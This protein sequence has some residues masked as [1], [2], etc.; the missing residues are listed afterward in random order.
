MESTASSEAQVL[1]P[2]FQKAKDCGN[3][4]YLYTLVRIDGMQCYEGYQDEFISLR[5]QL[6][7]LDPSDPLTH[8]RTLSCRHE[9]LDLIQNLLNCASGKYYDATPFRTLITGQYPNAVWP[10]PRQKA[11]YLSANARSS[12]FPELADQIEAAYPAPV[13]ESVEP[14][15]DAL[16]AALGTLADLLGDLVSRYFTKLVEFRKAPRY[17]K[18]PG[19]LDLL[20]LIVDEHLGLTGLRV[21]FS[22]NCSAEFIR[23]PHGVFPANLEFGP[24]ITFLRM[25]LEPSSNEYRVMGKRI[26][27]IGLPGRYNK[28]G[29]WKPLIYP[30][31]AQHLVDECLRLSKDPDVQ[32]ALLYTRLTGH[33][34]IEFAMK[35]DMELPGEYTKTAEGG[36]HIW[37]CPLEE[38]I[39]GNVRTYDCW[40]TLDSCSA[41]EIEGRLASVGWFM[42]VLFFPYGATYSWRNK[43][44]MTFGGKGVL[45]P[46]HEDLE[47]V[48]RILK[49]YPNTSD[50]VAL[51]SGMDW[52]NMGVSASN[53]FSGFLCYYIAF[54]SVAVAIYDGAELGGGLPARPN[55]AE[56]K[57][58]ATE[59][60]RTKHAE[61]F[62]S[63]PIRFVE[64]SYF[65]CVG[66]LKTK[67]KKVATAV[68]GEGHPYLK[69]LF[70]KPAVGEMSLSDLR[71]EL[72]HGGITM[73]EEAHRSVVSKS[74]YE[75]GNITREFLLRILFCLKPPEAV[76]SWSGRSQMSL[77]SAD[78]RLTMWSTT[79]K[80]FPEGTNWRIRPE[81]CE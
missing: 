56:R 55:R 78:P 62:D 14:A 51:A 39:D 47:T 76:P 9:P 54:E 60:I 23:L 74:L 65:D 45:M 3:F 64:Q 77:S 10:T 44:R 73:L 63:D 19:R 68:F 75:M 12:G 40:I 21:H 4:D 50:G 53:A 42:N 81:W 11:E 17:I 67:T 8:Y 71:S 43:Y 15:P 69:L 27:E 36:L 26:Y 48:D 30:G 59:C 49:T 7:G 72:A 25:S 31:N 34:C 66:S 33:K 29:E 28:P 37:R 32:G 61:L 1:E 70:E 58:L 46:S 22:E 5:D 2:L 41:E 79:D 38:R 24:P 16:R 18:I 6:D 13:V 80:V 52:Y 20:E 35:S 57:A